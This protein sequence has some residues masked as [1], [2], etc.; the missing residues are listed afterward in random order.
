MRGAA[1]AFVSLC[2]GVG[3]GAVTLKRD[4]TG[5]AGGGR[6]MRLR[7]TR[8]APPGNHRPGQ[9]LLGSPSFHALLTTYPS[10]CR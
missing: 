5:E 7:S 1:K 4:G 9:P 6:E 3:V 8:G 10:H 2:V